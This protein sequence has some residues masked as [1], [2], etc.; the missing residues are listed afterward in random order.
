MARFGFEAAESEAVAV[1]CRIR[2]L[3]E[4][5][6]AQEGKCVTVVDDETVQVAPP[7]NSKYFY[8]GKITNCSFKV[9]FQSI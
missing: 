9:S 4:E 6:E 5:D 1:L 8:N 2:P 7:E 3:S